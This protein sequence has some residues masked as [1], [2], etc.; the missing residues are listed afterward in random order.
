[1]RAAFSLGLGAT[2]RA[3]DEG[4]SARESRWIPVI[5]PLSPLTTLLAAAAVLGIA[6]MNASACATAA[7]LL[8]EELPC[9]GPVE[10]TD[11]H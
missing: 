3:E 11:T 4:L 2:T 10:A 9:I 5:V 6:W 1:M 8:V 7:T